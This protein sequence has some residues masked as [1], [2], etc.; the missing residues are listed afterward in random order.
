[1][2]ALAEVDM[3]GPAKLETIGLFSGAV[4][5][6]AQTE[7]GQQRAGQ[8]TTQWQGTLAGYLLRTATG[9]QYPQLAAALSGQ[10]ASPPASGDPAQHE[11]LFDRAMTRTLPDCSRPSQRP[12]RALV[13]PLI[14]EPRKAPNG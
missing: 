13:T 6:F 9:G 8:D 14:T 4:R 5:L 10:H 7:I 1:L 3:A 2:A 12:G 11:P